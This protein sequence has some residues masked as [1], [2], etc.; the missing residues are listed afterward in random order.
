MHLSGSIKSSRFQSTQN[1]I[2]AVVF[3]NDDVVN[4]MLGSL[5]GLLWYE[6]DVLIFKVCI[7]QV[8]SDFEIEL[9]NMSSRYSN[10]N[11]DHHVVI[12]WSIFIV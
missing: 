5:D 3:L 2:S 12:Y 8:T 6:P 7:L 10:S 11:F 4:V 1:S 9:L